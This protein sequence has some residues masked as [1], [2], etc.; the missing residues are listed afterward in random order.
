MWDLRS[1]LDLLNVEIKIITFDNDFLAESYLHHAN[2]DWPLLIDEK[3][4]TYE[5]YGL[6]RAGWWTLYNPL[7]ILR[8]LK[9]MFSGTRPG[10]PGKDWNQ[11]GGDVLIDP[12]GIVRLHYISKSPHDRP[13]IDSILEM[14]RSHLE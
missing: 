2:I 10:K 11:L 13:E 8:Y 6:Q 9:L 5:D 12:E 3:G 7:S 1:E 4:K 14:V